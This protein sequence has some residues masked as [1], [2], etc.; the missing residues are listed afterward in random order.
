MGFKVAAAAVIAP[1]LIA[2][3]AADEALARKLY[4]AT[5]SNVRFAGLQ[6]ADGI[7]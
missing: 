2:H 7:R 3:L 4:A 1:A 5:Q 6:V